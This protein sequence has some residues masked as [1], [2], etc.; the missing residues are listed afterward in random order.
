MDFNQ[1]NFNAFSYESELCKIGLKYQ[2]DKSPLCNNL[3]GFHAYTPFYNT[4]F[5]SIR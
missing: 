2:T 3:V 5:S 1:I 4:L